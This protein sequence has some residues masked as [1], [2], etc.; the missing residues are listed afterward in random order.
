MCNFE[1]MSLPDWRISTLH[2]ISLNN[3]NSPLSS[4]IFSTLLSFPQSSLSLP[5]SSPRYSLFL[6]LLFL[7]LFLFLFLNPLLFFFYLLSFYFWIFSFT[8]SLSISLSFPPLHAPLPQENGFVGEWEI[9]WD[10]KEKKK[11]REEGFCYTIFPL[12]HSSSFIV[13]FFFFYYRLVLPLCQKAVEKAKKLR[14][15]IVE[16]RCTLLMLCLACIFIL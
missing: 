3:R 12:L 2:L 9:R 5:Q 1:L 15:F 16:K 13:W 10:Q 8:P 11:T 6:N 7:P 14:G 4:W